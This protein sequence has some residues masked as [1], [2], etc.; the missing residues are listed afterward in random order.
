MRPVYQETILPNIAYIGGGGELA[1][2]L[3]LRWLFQALQVPMPVVM[4]RTS[5]AFLTSK[6]AR[7]WQATGL[8]IEDLFV[9]K[10]ELEKRLA[11]R[12][13]SFTTSLGAERS[14][15]AAL[16]DALA[17]R[18]RAADPTLEPSVRAKEA[19]SAKGLDQIE[20]RLVHAA[21]R[22]QT[23]RLR[24][25]SE[26]V[27]AVFAHGLQ[28]RRENFMPKYA[29]EGP[30]LFD[31]LMEALDPLDPRFSVLEETAGEA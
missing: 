6:Q 5:A 18:V 7:K 29:Q 22:Q 9:A 30:G 15:H 13:A 19:F 2:W 23:D 1:Y 27:D 8:G 10:D 26:V 4:L 20:R 24:R 14:T 3:Q 16:F 21:K 31:R 28:E 17:A 25:M 12:H 11:L